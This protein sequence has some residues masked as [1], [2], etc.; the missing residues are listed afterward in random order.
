MCSATRSRPIPCGTFDARNANPPRETSAKDLPRSESATFSRSHDENDPPAK[1]AKCG[2]FYRGFQSEVGPI[3]LT[4]FSF[5]SHNRST[6]WQP[7]QGPPIPSGS[8]ALSSQGHLGRACRTWQKRCFWRR[9][10]ATGFP[11]T[12]R[13]LPAKAPASSKWY[14]PLVGQQGQGR[15]VSR[16][17]PPSRARRRLPR[18]AVFTRSTPRGVSESVGPSALPLASS[19][20]DRGAALRRPLA[21]AATWSAT[22]GRGPRRAGDEKRTS[23]PPRWPAASPHRPRRCRNAQRMPRC[24]TRQAPM[25][26]GGREANSYTRT[27]RSRSAQRRGPMRH[28]HQLAAVV[29]VQGRAGDDRVRSRAW[30]PEAARR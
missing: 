29:R 13:L 9:S 18:A 11:T 23:R 25:T 28:R 2:V 27:A 17:N 15:R 19:N 30:R 26:V 12:R 7:W 10:R 24:S 14:P 4:S 21:Q 5:F 8:R 1:V 16:L 3:S 6:T 20:S 22:R